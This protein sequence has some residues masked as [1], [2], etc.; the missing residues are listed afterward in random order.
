[1]IARHDDL[2]KLGSAEGFLN[3]LCGRGCLVGIPRPETDDEGSCPHHFIKR[4]DGRQLPGQVM[5]V[6]AEGRAL[7]W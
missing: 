4:T 7:A 1:M 5:G 3:R 6:T 2:L